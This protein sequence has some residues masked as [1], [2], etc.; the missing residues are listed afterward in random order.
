MGGLLLAREPRWSSWRL[1]LEAAY[2]GGLFF[3]VAVLRA[4]DAFNKSNPLTWALAGGC[5]A[6]LVVAPFVYLAMQRTRAR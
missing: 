3:L 5:G 4:W 6:F 1:I 2:V